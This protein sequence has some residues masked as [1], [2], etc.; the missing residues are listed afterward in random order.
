MC[1][2][3]SQCRGSAQKGHLKCLIDGRSI[4]FRVLLTRSH[5]E[6]SQS[7]QWQHMC[8][9]SDDSWEHVPKEAEG[10]IRLSG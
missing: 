7:V 10:H 9:H 4:N 1:G 2:Q 8:C 5:A 6:S 3:R